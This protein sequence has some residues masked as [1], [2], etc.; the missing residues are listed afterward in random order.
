LQTSPF[1]IR[2]FS[3]ISDY[4]TVSQLQQGMAVITRNAHPYFLSTMF[5]YLVI[6]AWFGSRRSPI[7]LKMTHMVVL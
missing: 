3:P 6:S 5:K 4:E 7:P 1:G 2:F